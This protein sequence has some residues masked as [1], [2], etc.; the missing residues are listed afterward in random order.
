MV[1]WWF[2]LLNEEEQK[3]ERVKQKWVF[4]LLCEQ[5]LRADASAFVD[6]DCESWVYSRK[7]SGT[8]KKGSENRNRG[9]ERT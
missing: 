8:K 3:R 1:V 4:A 9:K 7:S 6:G 5:R 2:Y